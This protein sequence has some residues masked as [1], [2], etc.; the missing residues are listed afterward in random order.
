M[1]F[2]PESLQ[3]SWPKTVVRKWLNIKSR[4]D[5]FH[6]DYGI[7]STGA[8]FSPSMSVCSCAQ[9]FFLK[10]LIGRV[11]CCGCCFPFLGAGSGGGMEERRKSCSDKDRCYISL[12]GDHLLSGTHP[13]RPCCSVLPCSLRWKECFCGYLKSCTAA[14]NTVWI[15]EAGGQ[16]KNPILAAATARTASH[17]RSLIFRRG[18][19]WRRRGKSETAAARAALASRLR[20]SEPETNPQMCA[21]AWTT[22]NLGKNYGEHRHHEANPHVKL[23]MLN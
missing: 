1:G 18:F 23:I 8:P 11:F 13:I 20:E 17:D 5:E 2:A 19:G 6:S 22:L 9:V 14:A 16:I 21:A 15:T 12:K 10:F 3:S 4:A 7:I